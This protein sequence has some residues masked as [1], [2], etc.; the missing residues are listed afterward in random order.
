MILPP[1]GQRFPRNS[2]WDYYIV[3]RWKKQGQQA[4]PRGE[5]NVYLQLYPDFLKKSLHFPFKSDS[6][7]LLTLF[8]VVKEVQTHGKMRYLR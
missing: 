3:Q 2:F 5:F 7:L 6:I 8:Q 1:Q 4:V